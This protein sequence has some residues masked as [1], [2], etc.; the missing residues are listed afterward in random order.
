MVF[1]CLCPYVVKNP[2]HPPSWGY[3][4]KG[5]LSPSEYEQ[6]PITLNLDIFYFGYRG[7]TLTNV[8]PLKEF[9][10]LTNDGG[11]GLILKLESV[12]L[13]NDSAL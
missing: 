2:P 11:G 13:R 3:M 6:I 9:V 7:S 12:I 8:K 5:F 1:L 10:S 4:G